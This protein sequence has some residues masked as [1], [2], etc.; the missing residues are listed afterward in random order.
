MS[1]ESP[2]FQPGAVLHDA[3]VGA[4]KSRGLGFE[5][6]CKA[7][8]IAASAARNATFG[9]SKGPKGRAL[10]ARMIA[11]AGPEIVEAAYRSRMKQHVAALDRDV[12]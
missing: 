3:I 12:A 1:K 11:D 7:N 2:E 9:Q 4:F 5:A 10:L 8:D 6:W